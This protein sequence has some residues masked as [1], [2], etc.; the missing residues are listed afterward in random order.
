MIQGYQH[1]FWELPVWPGFMICLPHLSGESCWWVLTSGQ[2]W[3]IH[4]NIIG[5]FSSLRTRIVLISQT[6]KILMDQ[7]TS[8]WN[9][10]PWFWGLFISWKDASAY[11]MLAVPTAGG[12]TIVPK[13]YFLSSAWIGLCEL[14][15]CQT[16]VF[17]IQY[18]RCCGILM[19]WL[20]K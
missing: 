12:N 2:I 10:T 15:N 5:Q 4:F 1:A 7:T 17:Y 19:K 11:Q 16:M 8:Q 14:P 18:V 20:K 6:L 9:E 13:A 3:S